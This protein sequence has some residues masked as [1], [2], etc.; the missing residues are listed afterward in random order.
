MSQ[1][2]KIEWTA[3]T[4]N[5]VTGCTK[6]SPGCKN[7]YAEREWSRLSANPK[8][9]YHGREFTDVQCHPERLNLPLSWQKPRLIFVNSMGD[10][11]HPEVSETFIRSVFLVMGRAK[12]HRFQVL[13]KYAWRMQEILF[14]GMEFPEF[15][16]LQYPLPNVWIGVSCENQITANLR[17]PLLLNT[18]AAIRFVS[19]EPLLGPIDLTDMPTRYHPNA[20][21]LTWYR[22]SLDWVIVGGETGPNARPMDPAWARSLRDQCVK[23]DVPFFFKQWGQWRPA[24]PGEKP[25][26]MFR[27]GRK[28]AGRLLDGQEWTQYPYEY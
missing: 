18:P 15:Y 28:A 2:S 4:W 12:R 25:S 11:F 7:C 22:P 23:S 13:T 24:L 5:P 3:A 20:N 8:T 14:P 9:V 19:L 1:N 10:L 26:D 16:G 27:V 17:I 6:S 21:V